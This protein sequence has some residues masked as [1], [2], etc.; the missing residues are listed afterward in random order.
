MIH[1]DLI[2]GSEEWLAYRCG[3][4][5]GSRIS[6]LTRK[7]KS[8]DSATRARYMGELI[9]ERLTRIPTKTFKS[10]D[11][12]NG[13]EREPR[14]RALYE[15]RWDGEIE[16]VGF[17]DHPTIEM[18]G[19]SP[20]G[21][22]GPEGGVEIKCPIIATHLETLETKKCPLDYLKQIQWNMACSSALWWDYVSF[23]PE[24]PARMQLF[25]ARIDRDISW[26][27]DLETEVRKFLAELN[28]KLAAL[29]A[30]YGEAA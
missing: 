21:L 18:A 30:A 24:L 23:C 10:S 5:T 16:T 15:L 22:M 17:I 12:E 20:D 27:A 7:T 8:G 19:C 11:M 26:I 9:A 4:V 25:V 14:A 3:R 28:A 2:Q 1:A 6:D 13:K 29:T